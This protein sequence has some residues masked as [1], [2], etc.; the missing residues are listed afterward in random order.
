MKQKQKTRPHPPI[1]HRIRIGTKMYSIDI[2]ESM[3]RKREM[4]RVT[5][6]TQNIQIGTTSNVTGKRYSDIQMSETFWH[7]LVHAI[8]YE[9]D[10]QLHNDEKFVDTFAMHLSRAIQ[11]AKFK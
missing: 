2:V 4:G 7:E 10:S 9:M 3:Y 6:G 8:L 1:P 11:S 5:Y